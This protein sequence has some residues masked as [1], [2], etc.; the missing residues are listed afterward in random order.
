MAD[1]TKDAAG[2]NQADKAQQGEDSVYFADWA[3]LPMNNGNL[4]FAWIG[5]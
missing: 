5:G 2:A 4:A 1:E 3:Q